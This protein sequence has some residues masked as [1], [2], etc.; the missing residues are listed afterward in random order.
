ML[1]VIKLEKLMKSLFA[2]LCLDT[3]P[4]HCADLSEVDGESYSTMPAVIELLRVSSSV[5][6]ACLVCK[7]LRTT[8]VCHA[9]VV[10]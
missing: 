8:L 3:G 7:L 9:C 6:S 4:C 1:D 5:S 2:S 10:R